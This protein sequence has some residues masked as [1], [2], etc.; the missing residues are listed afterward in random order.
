MKT[1]YPAI[2]HHEDDSYWVEF[3][4]LEGCQSFGDTLEET[5]ANAREAL[6]GY[7]VALLDQKQSLTPASDIRQISV[8]EGCFVSIVEAELKLV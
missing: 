7:C 4:D 6:A 2:F 8:P 3:P 5:L 1:I